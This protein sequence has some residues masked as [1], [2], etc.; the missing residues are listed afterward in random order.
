MA[1]KER[2]WTCRACLHVT[3]ALLRTALEH[4]P[5][6]GAERHANAAAPSNKKRKALPL[7]LDLP[8]SSSS[9]RDELQ[10]TPMCIEYPGMPDWWY[11]AL[12]APAGSTCPSCK[13]VEPH[14]DRTRCSISSCGA[15]LV[16]RGELVRRGRREMLVFLVGLKQPQSSIC[17]H[18]AS[19]ALYDR[20]L[21][22]LILPYLVPIT[23]EFADGE[24][25]A[26]RRKT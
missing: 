26:K 22:H 7:A 8:S 1:T 16:D 13:F 9:S 3:S 24:R 25:T 12:E 15:W 5:K 23:H 20:R 14:P 17:R 21:L 2:G 6:C 11:A 10:W 4:C 19:G 18:L